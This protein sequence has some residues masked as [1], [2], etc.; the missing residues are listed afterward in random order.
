M[1]LM[2]LI[3][4]SLVVSLLLPAMVS[5]AA[6][7]WKI[8]HEKSSLAFAATQNGAPVTGTFAKFDG[9][10]NFDPKH[11]DDCKVKINVDMNSLSTSY[12]DLTATLKTPDWFNIKLFP[13]AVFEASKFEKT[14]ENQYVA[15]GKLT[16]RNK[17]LPVTLNFTAEQ[18]TP[19]SAVIKGSTVLE[20]TAFGVGQGEWSSVSEIKNGVTVN[21]VVAAA[22]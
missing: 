12:N 5:A 16:I 17:T 8:V 18:S 20:R 19:D 3:R 22:K 2:H 15:K 9:T 14:G 6:P 1:R 21:F 4:R 13:Q 10:I 11:L 7:A